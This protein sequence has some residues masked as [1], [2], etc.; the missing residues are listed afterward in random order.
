MIF[1]NRKDAGEKLAQKLHAY[2]NR[3]QTIVLGL[4]RGGVVT[5]ACVAHDLNLPLDM[6]VT[7]K[8]GAPHN[9]ELAIGA[10]DE[11]GHMVLNQEL[12]DLLHISKDYVAQVKHKE[13]MEASLQLKKFRGSKPP[14]ILKNKTAI[15]IDDGLATGATMR[16]AIA[17]AKAKQS[18]KI[19]VAVPVASPEI[20]DQLKEEVDEIV[21]CYVPMNL[22][23][24]GMYYEDF[25]QTED[26]EVI[27][28]LMGK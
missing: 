27:T 5:A 9:P 25:D 13:Q 24:V 19:I 6:L 15:L 17:S 16:A 20:L 2:R 12:I 11:K 8:M 22:G 7:Q 14:L 23:A 26:E 1:K 28:L 18:K 10:V 4:P 3:P 21:A